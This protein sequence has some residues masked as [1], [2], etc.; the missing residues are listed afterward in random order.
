M[1]RSKCVS[2]GEYV[3]VHTLRV[4]LYT[5]TLSKLFCPLRKPAAS[6]ACTPCSQLHCW[7]SCYCPTA[8]TLCTGCTRPHPVARARALAHALALA[9]A[10]ALHTRLTFRLLGSSTILSIS[11]ATGCC[12]TRLL[13]MDCP[14]L[15]NC[16]SARGRAQTSR[17]LTGAR[18]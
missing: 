2:G 10:L 14:A 3:C 12:F 1:A 11:G 5:H 9:L 6:A 15:S 17:L 18:L 13:L 4:N 7:P 16:C 8:N